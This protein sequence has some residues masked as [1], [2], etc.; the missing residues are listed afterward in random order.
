MEKIV[1]KTATVYVS[2]PPKRSGARQSHHDGA[3]RFTEFDAVS[4]EEERIPV[5]E[6]VEVV[7]VVG[8][9]LIVKRKEA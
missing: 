3:G 5:D 1:G 6:T 7:E 8:D 2:I 4:D 9:C